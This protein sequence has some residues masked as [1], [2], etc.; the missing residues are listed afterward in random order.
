MP[1]ADQVDH[2]HALAGQRVLRRER[3]LADRRTRGLE[4]GGDH[5]P[6]ASVGLRAGDPRADLADLL[7]VAEGALAVDRSRSRE[8]WRH[9]P[10]REPSQEVK[11]TNSDASDGQ[12]DRGDQQAAHEPL[13]GR[14][15]VGIISTFHAIRLLRG[16]VVGT[17]M[18]GAIV[19]RVTAGYVSSKRASRSMGKPDDVG[20]AAADD[21]D[22]RVAVLDAVSRPTSLPPA[23]V[24]VSRPLAVAQRPEPDDADLDGADPFV[25][26]G[27]VEAKPGDDLGVVSFLEPDHPLGVGS[28]QRLVEDLAV[29]GADRIGRRG[30][31]RARRRRRHGRRLPPGQVRRVFGRRGLR[32]PGRA[33][34]RPTDRPRRRSRPLRATAAAGARHWPGSSVGFMDVAARWTDADRS[35]T[36]AFD[37]A[38]DRTPLASCQQGG[39]R[40]TL[41]GL[42]RT[43]APHEDSHHEAVRSSPRSLLVLLLCR[44]SPPRSRPLRTA[45]AWPTS[46]RSTR[47]IPTRTSPS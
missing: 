19:Q 39:K 21:G 3:L 7:E 14:A 24:E 6:L 13:A 32:T 22:E 2:V 43:D 37:T 46:T 28:V 40:R 9:W 29:D 8:P 41:N 17:C 10:P 42:A 36:I 25:A 5:L 12:Q 18:A 38:P 35:S 44:R 11:A 45:T 16:T 33:R 20:E 34:R 31:A 4:M 27:P 15:S 1:R 47:I 26:L 30:S 23:R